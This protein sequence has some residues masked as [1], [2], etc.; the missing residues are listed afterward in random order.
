MA[1]IDPTLILDDNRADTVN[2]KTF[3]VAHNQLEQALS[4]IFGIELGKNITQSI[5]GTVDSDGSFLTMRFTSG[6]S[7]SN[8]ET[9]PG[10]IFD[11]GN[12]IK[13]IT[14]VGSKVSLWVKSG[15]TWNR[16]AYDYE[17]DNEPALT[18][19]TDCAIDTL[20]LNSTA[21]S[22]QIVGTISDT[23][24]GTEKIKFALTNNEIAEGGAQKFIDLNEVK[25]AIDSWRLRGSSTSFSPGKTGYLVSI[26]GANTLKPVPNP[27]DN[28]TRQSAAFSTKVSIPK[29]TFVV[30]SNWEAMDSPDSFGQG[31]YRATFELAR[32]V[33]QCSMNLN[34][35]Q[36]P[37]TK[38]V[39][40]WGMTGPIGFR[41]LNGSPGHY[42]TIPIPWYL[43]PGGTV[44]GGY[45][46]P[47]NQLFTR[48]A[49]EYCGSC[50]I[51]MTESFGL[52]NAQVWQN[53]G[54]TMQADL[55]LSITRIA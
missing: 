45:V 37:D 48:N 15:S 20:V 33:Y 32:G 13:K 54:G 2:G 21:R 6:S 1:D 17:G 24:S 28:S 31:G 44:F 40:K 39:F 34:V 5:L 9:Q 23:S 18:D 42:I 50:L 14:M 43:K 46:T 55:E 52:V 51:A 38:G 4:N 22:G 26:A 36:S 3:V 12:A 16:Q 19:F 53:G 35:T 8:P 30:P 47:I 41:I 11:D 25:A 49:K 29:E 27:D 10:I 7:S